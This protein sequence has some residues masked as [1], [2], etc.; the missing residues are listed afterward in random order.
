[1]SST[2]LRL[3]LSGSKMMKNLLRPKSCWRQMY[4]HHYVSS[5]TFLLGSGAELRGQMTREPVSLL[6]HLWDACSGFWS[7]ACAPLW[8]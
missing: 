8:Q 4:V 7:D 3:L 5:T 2:Q 1:M 6:M